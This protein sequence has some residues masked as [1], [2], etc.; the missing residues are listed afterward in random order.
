MSKE[1]RVAIRAAKEAGKIL[2]QHYG[3]IKKITYK[4]EYSRLTA[5]DLLAEKKIIGIIKKEF[6]EYS[7]YSEEKGFETK[8]SDYMWVIDPL[9]GTTNYSIMLPFFNVAIGLAFKG[10]PI[11]GV[12]YYP[13]YNELFYAEKGKGAFLN[14]K[15]I[16]VSSKK[17][18]IKSVVG[19]CHGERTPKAIKRATEIYVN[20]KRI[21]TNRTRQFGSA[22]LEL[23]YCA[24]GRI[25]AFEMSDMN[26][27]DVAAG[28]AI[29]RE[30]GG[31]VTDF[32]NKKFD[33]KSR[34]I[35]A[36]NGILHKK[37]L[38]IIKIKT[39]CRSL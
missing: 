5:A 37:I 36:S 4:K 22:A 30:A 31:K 32:E 34:D 11:L 19:Y 13:P 18:L 35:L 29:V 27:Y 15:R 28:V 2:K 16:H 7:I 26:A 14:G 8:K 33:L 25:D 21:A 6:P 20:L 9:D 3:K 12:V 10:E 1:L 39:R 23:S 38:N 17:E 24:C